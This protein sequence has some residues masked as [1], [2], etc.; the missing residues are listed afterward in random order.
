MKDNRGLRVDLPY[1]VSTPG[2]FYR[3]SPVTPPIVY[4]FKR[5]A[6][7]RL[8]ARG[9]VNA[10]CLAAAFGERKKNSLC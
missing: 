2:N 5:F 8:R 4:G 9:C 6:V 10:A 7:D 3:L 1:D